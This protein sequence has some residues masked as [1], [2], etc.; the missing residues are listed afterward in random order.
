MLEV[1]DGRRLGDVVQQLH[2]RMQYPRKCLWLT[3]SG[4]SMSQMQGEFCFYHTEEKK[5]FL[6][7]DAVDNLTA[8]SGQEQ[9]F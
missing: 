1:R 4:R 2:G 5:F 9:R 7:G 8:N 3:A 6:L